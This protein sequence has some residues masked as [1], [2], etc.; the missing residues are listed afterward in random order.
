MMMNDRKETLYRVFRTTLG[1]DRVDDT[2]SQRNCEQWDSLAH[3]NLIVALEEAFDLSFEPE[4][5]GSMHS[6][7]EV[8]AVLARK[9]G[10]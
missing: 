6:H 4:E 5:M 10:A 2:L 3:L 9:L 1:I 8:E 7:A